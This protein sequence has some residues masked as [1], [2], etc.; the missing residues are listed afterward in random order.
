MVIPEI[1]SEKSSFTSKRLM[2]ESWLRCLWISDVEAN[3][4]RSFWLLAGGWGLHTLPT[5]LFLPVVYVL[6]LFKVPYYWQIFP[7]TWVCI[8]RGCYP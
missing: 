6:S 5:V 4:F 8:F 2:S 3:L 1:N 7:E